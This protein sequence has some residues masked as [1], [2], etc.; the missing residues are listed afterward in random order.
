MVEKIELIIDLPPGFPIRYHDAVMRAANMCGV[1]K[2]LVDP[3][4]I[5]VSTVVHE[6]G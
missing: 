1:K 3:P 6:S 2:H 4:E 5:V